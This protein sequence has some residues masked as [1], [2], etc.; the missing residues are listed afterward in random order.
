MSVAMIIGAAVGIIGPIGDL[1][2]SMLKREVGLKDTG[3]LLPGHGG[4]LD[5]MDSWFWAA[6]IGF[7]LI[8]FLS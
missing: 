1:G 4:A 8:I 7:H 2:I 6:L 3:T 5:R